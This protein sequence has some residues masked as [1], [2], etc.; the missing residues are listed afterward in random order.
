MSLKLRGLLAVCIGLVLGVCLTVGPVVQADRDPA[1]E[2]NLPWEEARLLA[3]VLERV[4]RDYVEAVDDH[5]LIEA[6]IRGMVSD[7]DP[8]SAF[9]APDEFQEIRISTSGNYM[10]IGLEVSVENDQVVV[11]TPMDGSPAAEAG[12][13]PGDIVLS[14]DGMPVDPRDLDD[15]VARMRGSPG[16][17]VV[18]GVRRPGV[19]APM[20]FELARARIEV[21]SVRSELLESGYGYVRISHFSETTAQDLARVLGELSA[22]AGGPLRGLVLDLRNNPGGVL[23]AAVAVADAFLDGGLIVTAD[24][25]MPEARFRIEATTGDLLDGSP[26][27]VLVNGGSAS[28]SEIVAGALKDQERATVVGTVTFGKGSVQTVMPLSEGRAI[29]LTTSRYYTPSGQSIHGRGIQP[30]VTVEPGV[31]ESD[32]P[33]L[34]AALKTLKTLR[35]VQRAP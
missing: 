15:T 17:P 27:T 2:E 10:G 6:A 5:E 33:Q 9:L 24:G 12:V 16:T 34:A 31:E 13:Q 3:E 35:V 32:D 14:I 22:Q 28:A 30:D 21:H 23:E 18:L 4:K 29:K 20:S 11:V 26:V 19:D 1:V 8:H 25:R 7:L